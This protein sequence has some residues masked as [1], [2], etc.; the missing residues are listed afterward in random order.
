MTR[1]LEDVR[2]EVWSQLK[3]SQCVYLATAEG[4]QPRV[5]P[6][7][8]LDIDKK[9]WIATSPR[10]A[11]ARQILRNPSVEFCIP[12]SEECGNGYIRIAGVAAIVSD[13]AVRTKI[14]EKIPFLKEHW[15]GSDD[16]SFCLI[17]ITRV[18]VEYL[19]PGEMEAQTF[20]V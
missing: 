13:P 6:V 15:S 3:D 19:K 10:S 18:E 9:F 8:L 16:P 7:T 17:R 5:R 4:D 2:Q 11:K 1:S 14:G 20:I 12:L